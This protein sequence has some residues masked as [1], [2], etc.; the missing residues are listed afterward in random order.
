[1]SSSIFF[2]RRN[3]CGQGFVLDCD[4]LESVE[5]CDRDC[6]S[7]HLTYFWKEKKEDL[8]LSA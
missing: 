3:A 7:A 2:V 8:G 1:V 6:G 4:F 5:C